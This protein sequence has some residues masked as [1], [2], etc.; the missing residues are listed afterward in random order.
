MKWLDGTALPAEGTA[1]ALLECIADTVY[2]FS[3]EQWLA[4][5]MPVRTACFLLDFDTEL[6]MEGIFT[7]LENTVGEYLPEVIAAFA[8]IGD[9]TDADLLREIVRIAPPEILRGE[10]LGADH[11]EYDITCFDDDHEL[12]DE[13]AARIEALE[14]Q[15]YLNTGRDLYEMLK[16]YIE[17]E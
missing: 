10:M 12:T 14:A 1:D 15:L 6:Q 2:D 16:S 7:C 3:R 8:R 17:K 4:A 9:E 11:A 5:E 13:A